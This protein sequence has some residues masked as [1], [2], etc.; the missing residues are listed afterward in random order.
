MKR[1][2]HRA[3][4]FSR[5]TTPPRHPSRRRSGHHRG[6]GQCH[7]RRRGCR[8]GAAATGGGRP[9]P[10]GRLA[11]KSCRRLV[12]DRVR[13]GRAV[14]RARGEK[15][16]HPAVGGECGRKREHNPS[17]RRRIFRARRR[18]PAEQVRRQHHIGPLVR[19]ARRA[20]APRMQ[21]GK[22]GFGV[23][24]PERGGRRAV[25]ASHTR[26]RLVGPPGIFVVPEANGGEVGGSVWGGRSGRPCVVAAAAA[27]AAAV[28]RTR[29]AATASSTRCWT[30]PGPSRAA[31]GRRCR[32]AA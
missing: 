4:F 23:A 22:G 13:Q 19:R 2:T 24:V 10:A 27:A 9:Y 12:A 21:P 3:P 32:P 31:R 14:T 16:L 1:T 28:T 6:H 11:D 15:G 7:P 29:A 25:A 20:V 26:Q 5:L 30:W 17:H 8:W 18:V